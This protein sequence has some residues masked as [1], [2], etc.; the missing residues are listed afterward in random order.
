[1]IWTNAEDVVMIH[2]RIIQATGGMNGI[3]DKDCQT[4]RIDIIFF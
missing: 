1:M 4:S 2:S 3:R